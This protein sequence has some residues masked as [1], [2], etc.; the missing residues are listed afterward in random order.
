MNPRI[1]PAT[2]TSIGSLP[3]SDAAEAVS[4]VLAEHPALPAVPQLSAHDPM[5]SILGQVA[6]SLTGATV[7]F[8]GVLEIANPDVVDVIDSDPT[9]RGWSGMDAFLAATSGRRD[10]VKLQVAGP[11]TVA[12]A[13]VREG[14]SADRAMRVAAAA[15]GAVAEKTTKRVTGNLPGA[16]I[17]AFLD[18][19]GLTSM[20]RSDFPFAI[21]EVVDL[22][23]G[24]LAS[25]GS[26]DT[27][28]HCCGPADWHV[29]AA[30]GPTILSLPAEPLGESAP[31]IAAHL[32]Q[33]GWVAW[34]AVPTDR[35][36]GTN[37]D[38]QWRALI[39]LW[40]E[41][42]QNGCDPVRLR[43][44]AL[45]T[46]ACGLAGHGESQAHLVLDLTRQIAERVHGQA[47]AARLSV[48]A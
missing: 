45:I 28:V 26:A 44:Q 2:A 37:P 42:T 10:A 12:L 34:G 14:V 19:P 40:C 30:A 18:E 9:G 3:H 33:G 23:A 29:V 48:G 35:P 24:T 15:T 20:G 38:P 25:F 6:L 27:G 22:L 41:L 39:E 32:D 16:P 31:A 36:I 1:E 13:L 7:G 11:V 47:V 17:V 4:L 5:E 46:P 8:G 43:R 21:D